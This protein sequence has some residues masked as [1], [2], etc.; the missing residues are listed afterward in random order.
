MPK[1]GIGAIKTTTGTATVRTITRACP[2]D[3]FLH[4]ANAGF[5]IPIDRLDTNLR[6]GTAGSFG[7]TSR[8]APSWFGAEDIRRT[9]SPNRRV[10]CPGE[11][12]RPGFFTP[13]C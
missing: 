13:R 4:P 5:G 1:V 9:T 6:P 3:T 10:T 7:T 11:D 12:N 8:W 2:S